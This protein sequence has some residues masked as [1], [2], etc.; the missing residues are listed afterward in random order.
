MTGEVQFSG[1]GGNAS[2]ERLRRFDQLQS[3]EKVLSLLAASTEPVAVENMAIMTGL[4]VDQVLVY[5]NA[6]ERIKQY[7]KD[8]YWNLSLVAIQAIQ[9][10]YIS[11]LEE[12]KTISAFVSGAPHP[13]RYEDLPEKF[14]DQLGQEGKAFFEEILNQSNSSSSTAGLFLVTTNYDNHYYWIEKQTNRGQ[15]I[16]D[17]RC[18]RANIS[19]MI[20]YSSKLSNM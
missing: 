9:P 8:Y 1:V 6:D 14:R 12:F 4:T 13:V 5:L 2:F 10:N 3:E 19:R 16:R 18:D 20:I 7:P 15:V 11:K 17:L